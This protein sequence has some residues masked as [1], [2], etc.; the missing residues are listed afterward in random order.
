MNN[1]TNSHHH[2]YNFKLSENKS[3]DFQL[4]DSDDT[5]S[6]SLRIEDITPEFLESLEFNLSTSLSDEDYVDDILDD[7]KL[8]IYFDAK[9]TMDGNVINNRRQWKDNKLEY[10]NSPHFGLT[11]LDNG[12]EPVTGSIDNSLRNTPL[13]LFEDDNT[14]ELHRVNGVRRQLSYNVNVVDDVFKFRGGF[15]QGF[16]KVEGYD[17]QVL[18]NRYDRGWTIHTRLEHRD[19]EFPN[20]LNTYTTNDVGGFFFYMGTRAENK[21][22]NTFEP[23][24]HYKD[25]LVPEIEGAHIPLNPPRVLVKREDNQFLIYGQSGGSSICNTKG[26]PKTG[27]GTKTASNFGRQPLY[28]LTRVRIDDDEINPFLKYGQSNGRSICGDGTNVDYVS[29]ETGKIYD[30]GTASAADDVSK[31]DQSTELDVNKDL[32]DNA[33]GFRIKDDGSIGYRRIIKVDCDD[34]KEF[35]VKEEYSEPGTIPPNKMVNITLKWLADLSLVCQEDKPRNG[36]LYIYIND[37]LKVTFSNF[38]EIINKGLDEYRD[39]QLGVPFNISIG[40]GTQGLLESVT[41]DGP[42]PSDEDLLIETNFAGCFI[43]DMQHFKM[44]AEPLS[45]CEI[46]KLNKVV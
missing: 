35:E 42:D 20:T 17:Y 46:K 45:W 40:G 30:Y 2:K 23:E 33:I 25:V 39:K 7:Q 5:N 36:T 28:Y 9:H 3:Y 34:T 4:L 11:A 32:I 26:D 8:M 16:Y 27:F 15:Y 13:N 22:W 43:G 21:F 24:M 37:H 31:L 6:T 38:N 18:P 14:L 41:F 19:S 29:P 1:I 44:Y 12:R 10:I